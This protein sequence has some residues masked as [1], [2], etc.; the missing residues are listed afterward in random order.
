MHHDLIALSDRFGKRVPPCGEQVAV[1]FVFGHETLFQVFGQRMPYASCFSRFG[2]GLELIAVSQGKLPGV[3]VGRTVTVLALYL[4]GTE[5][6]S[7]IEAVPVM[8]YGGMTVLAEHPLGVVDILLQMQVALGMQLGL[9]VPLGIEVG[10]VFRLH[11][12]LVTHPDAF[13]AIMAG[14]TGLHR[15][16]GVAFIMDLYLDLA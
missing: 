16:P 10:L 4:H 6:R 12:P 7:H 11:Q 2:R 1:P 5:V 13:S 3:L 14:R 15:D 9:S 8:V